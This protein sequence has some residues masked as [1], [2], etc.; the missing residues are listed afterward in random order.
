MEAR[1]LRR[2]A[3]PVAWETGRV[4]L[5]AAVAAVVLGL[6]GAFGWVE[7]WLGFCFGVP[8]LLLGLVAGARLRGARTGLALAAA[9]A[10]LGAYGILGAVVA[11]TPVAER[12]PGTPVTVAATLPAEPPP[13]PPATVNEDSSGGTPAPAPVKP[14]RAE[15]TPD[16]DGGS[17]ML[18]LTLVSPLVGATA[19]LGGAWLGR[20]ERR[21]SQT[22]QWQRDAAGVVVPV[23]A[24]LDDADPRR[25]VSLDDG[26]A[27]ADALWQRW[28]DRVRDPLL[29]LANTHPSSRLSDQAA[30]L[31]TLV[32]ESLT[33]TATLV[34]ANTSGPEDLEA[35]ADAHRQASGL[36]RDLL[37]TLRRRSIWST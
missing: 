19:A 29:V 8:A 31:A 33:R 23:Q 10:A 24:L 34:R 37:T 6:V 21:A 5:V 27:E 32:S 35:A 12:E 13:A 28:T 22:T 11:A 36:A 20:R 30:R 4:A 25:L 2:E 9:G 15:A 16:G 26:A 3:S 14:P 17:S 18:A 1:G 7:P